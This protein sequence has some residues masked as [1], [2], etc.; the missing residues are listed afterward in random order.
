MALTRRWKSTPRLV[1]VVLLAGWHLVGQKPLA[2]D[3]SCGP[4]RPYP[5]HCKQHLFAKNGIVYSWMTA[6]CT[7][8]RELDVQASA[9]A[10][11][12]DWEVTLDAWTDKYSSEIPAEAHT[13]VCSPDARMIW[14]CSDESANP[15]G[16]CEGPCVEP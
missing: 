1:V 12:C 5:A 6:V 10:I 2:Y 4:G 15:S 7:N 16:G 11:S 14:N 13:S 9:Q 8:D 3:Y